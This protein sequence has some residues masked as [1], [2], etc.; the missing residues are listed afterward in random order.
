[1]IWVLLLW[2]AVCCE[3]FEESAGEGVCVDTTE[4]ECEGAASV[5]CVWDSVRAICVDPGE[6]PLVSCSH[7]GEYGCSMA[8]SRCVYDGACRAQSCRAYDSNIAKCFVL[9]ECRW[10]D[11]PNNPDHTVGKCLDSHEG[12]CQVRPHSDCSH[13]GKCHFDA[14]L[15]ACKDGPHCTPLAKAACQDTAHCI[16]TTA[17]GCEPRYAGVRCE[18]RATNCEDRYCQEA[19]TG[20]SQVC[21]R[22]GRCETHA[23][24]VVCSADPHCAWQHNTEVCVEMYDCSVHQTN[25]TACTEAIGCVWGNAALFGAVATASPMAT[26]DAARDG[27]GLDADYCATFLTASACLESLDCHWSVLNGTPQCTSHRASVTCEFLS[28]YGCAHSRSCVWDTSG[29]EHV[30]RE[31]DETV[32]D[33]CSAYVSSQPCLADAG[34][35]WSRYHVK[36]ANSCRSRYF[37]RQCGFRSRFH[38]KNDCTEVHAACAAV[39]QETDIICSNITTPRECT[40][41]LCTWQHG[42]CSAGTPPCTAL[43]ESLCL[44]RDACF[45]NTTA[46]Q[47]AVVVPPMGCG[48]HATEPN[49]YGGDARDFATC[50]W[51]ERSKACLP[52]Q[53]VPCPHLSEVSCGYVVGC[54]WGG[55][56]YNATLGVLSAFCY[57]KSSVECGHT[58][59]CGWDTGR[60]VCF[61]RPGATAAPSHPIATSWCTADAAGECRLEGDPEAF[62]MIEGSFSSCRCTEGYAHFI[63][64]E[65]TV[66]RCLPVLDSK[67]ETRLTF[68]MHWDRAIPCASLSVDATLVAAEV[69]RRLGSDAARIGALGAV[70][71]QAL[72]SVWVEVDNVQMITVSRMMSHRLHAEL[73]AVIRTA[74]ELHT[75]TPSLA[76]ELWTSTIV[77]EDQCTAMHSRLSVIVPDGNNHCWALACTE[78]YTI[79]EDTGVCAKL[80][81]PPPEDDDG[82]IN[83]GGV[84]GVV[85]ACVLFFG[86][87]LFVMWLWLR[88]TPAER[89]TPQNTH[90]ESDADGDDTTD[91]DG[92]ECVELSD[93]GTEEVANPDHDAD[94]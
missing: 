61:A 26:C 45:F 87:I 84:A 43:T 46:Q 92:E 44:S 71:G 28:K 53:D 58:D 57:L 76:Q 41:R 75:L 19:H 62:C 38:C 91:A 7:L 72:T 55:L 52:R 86:M 35:Q 94:V 50:L 2:F 67:P 17:G 68:A 34:C 36:L 42:V 80:P 78:G 65:G 79:P 4:E 8:S 81:P 3:C 33:V 15:F 21:L 66:R 63:T 22:R 14:P 37:P 89:I 39:P 29:S 13:D 56:C 23:G 88:K 74:S 49:C 82:G 24:A 54:A 6:E 59:S 1:M 25:H 11:A 32:M 73:S 18:H 51:D 93:R 47:C 48:V 10:E 40:F 77:G 30:C 90:G 9:S 69:V 12:S 27:S 60:R 70:C 31:G 20:L 5:L 83:A 64:T 85:I 16:L